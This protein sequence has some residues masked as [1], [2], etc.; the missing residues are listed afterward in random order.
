MSNALSMQM[1]EIYDA[2]PEGIVSEPGN[3]KGELASFA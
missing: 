1:R 3:K 2:I